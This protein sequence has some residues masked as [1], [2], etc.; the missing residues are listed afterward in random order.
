M[1]LSYSRRVGVMPTAE[2]W[3]MTGRKAGTGMEQSTGTP[4]IEVVIAEALDAQTAERL[5]GLLA[6]ALELRPG[7]LVVDLTDCPFLDATALSVLLDAH[8]E[9]WHTGGRLTLRSPSPRLRRLLE[10]AHAHGV[11]DITDEQPVQPHPTPR[12]RT[13][14]ADRRDL[15]R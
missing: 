8:R 6:E 3:P 12:R 13:E 11:F 5:R 9:A 14:G 15:R 1:D 10:L 2:A 4:L 7:Q